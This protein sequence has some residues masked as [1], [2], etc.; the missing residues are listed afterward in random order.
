MTLLFLCLWHH[1]YCDCSIHYSP[2]LITVSFYVTLF[3]P[4]F[5]YDYSSFYS[6]VTLLF[7]LSLEDYDLFF[8]F[9]ECS[10]FKPSSLLYSHSYDF[11]LHL[12]LF[13][14]FFLSPLFPFLFSNFLIYCLSS[15]VSV[16]SP[17]FHRISS[18]SVLPSFLFYV[19]SSL[20]SLLP[21]F[22]HFFSSIS[23]L[24]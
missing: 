12:R 20:F 6:C 8:F 1:Y 24:P 21:L 5:S 23:A 4:L 16:L 11:S 15:I 14:F 22:F 9:P 3:S 18:T 17:L 10:F 7:H 19:R 2:L 13:I